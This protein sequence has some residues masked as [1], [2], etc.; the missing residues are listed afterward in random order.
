MYAA[1]DKDV[2]WPTHRLSK[3]KVSKWRNVHNLNAILLIQFFFLLLSRSSLRLENDEK[4][5]SLLITCI[6]TLYHVCIVLGCQP[7]STNLGE[8]RGPFVATYV[9]LKLLLLYRR[10]VL[11]LHTVFGVG[12]GSCLFLFLF[13]SFAFF[14]M[15]FPMRN[16][17]RL[18][19][20]RYFLTCT[21]L[22]NY[23]KG[24]EQR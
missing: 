11:Q 2:S 12:E 20:V 17:T 21:L 1:A 18:V 13:V 19:A 4:L 3:L 10:M 15:A 8:A 5:W 23:T 22:K 14:T 24:K 9:V 6:L 16:L 7:A